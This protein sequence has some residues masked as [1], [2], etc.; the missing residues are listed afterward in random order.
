MAIY[1][2]VCHDCKIFWEKEAPMSK[3]PRRTKCPE[4]S[5]L[6]EQNYT[7]APP[8]IYKGTDYRTPGRIHVKARTNPQN[9][10]EWYDYET[11]ETQKRLL[12]GGSM[13]RHYVIDAK[14]ALEKG[15]L[16]KVSDKVYKERV[17]TIKKVR[18]EVSNMRKNST[19]I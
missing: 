3:A 16:T 10:D 15:T 8:V 11:K 13:Y 12:A 18:R 4:C 7:S 5:K 1:E 9:I 6:R 14:S 19:K 17:K 2:F